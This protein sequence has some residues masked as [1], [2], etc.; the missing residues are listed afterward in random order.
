M[1]RVDKVLQWVKGPS[2]LDIGCAGHVPE[3]NSPYWLHGR[4]RKQFQDV[5]GI[6]INRENVGKLLKL[7]YTNIFVADAQNFSFSTTFDTIVAGEVI[8][9]LSNPGEFLK[10]CKIHLKPYGRL[11]ITTPYP[12]SLLHILYAIKNFPKTCSNSEH[13]LWLCPQTLKELAK[14]YKLSVIHVELI[15]DYRFDAGS[16]TYR[17][18]VRLMQVIKFLLPT[19]LRANTI[20]AVLENTM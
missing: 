8:E 13:T 17:F 10:N 7:G 4:I 12:F 11:V 19:R 18:F 9:H 5:V 1:T 3:P 6:D 2:V 16:G 20:L 14:R 15:E